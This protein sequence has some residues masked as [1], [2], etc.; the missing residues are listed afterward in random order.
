MKPALKFL[1][2]AMLASLVLGVALVVIAVSVAGSIDPGSIQINGEPLSLTP[3]DTGDWLMAV[4]GVALALLIVALVVPL[5]VLVPLA[6]AAVALV[7]ALLAVAGV[8]AMLF[9]PLILLVVAVWLIVR[10]VRRAKKRP[11]AGATIAG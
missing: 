2:W 7:G 1:G 8:V 4:G 11:E 3:L 5:A 6:I 10:L 9:A